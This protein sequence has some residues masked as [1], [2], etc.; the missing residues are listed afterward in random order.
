MNVNKIS[1]LNNKTVI[2]VYIY[3]NIL[4]NYILL[5]IRLL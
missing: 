5:F 3:N 1:I 4:L 2:N